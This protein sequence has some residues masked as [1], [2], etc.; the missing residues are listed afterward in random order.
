MVDVEEDLHDDETKKYTNAA[1][2]AFPIAADPAVD[3]HAAPA[4]D[5]HGTAADPLAA[6]AAARH[7]STRLYSLNSAVID[8]NTTAG[9]KIYTAADDAERFE[10]TPFHLKASCGCSTAWGPR[11]THRVTAS[12]PFQKYR[13]T[14]DQQVSSS[15]ML[16]P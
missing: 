14:V 3:Q 11:R 9:A 7:V 8:Y 16:E 6:A 5:Q 1:A 12:S 2:A 10:Y 15:R 13:R 4:V